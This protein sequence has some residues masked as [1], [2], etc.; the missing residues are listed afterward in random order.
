MQYTLGHGDFYQTCVKNCIGRQMNECDAMQKNTYILTHTKMIAVGWDDFLLIRW[1]ISAAYKQRVW[2]ALTKKKICQV[3]LLS[4][5]AIWDVGRPRWLIKWRPFSFGLEFN[6]LWNRLINVHLWTT[7]TESL[8]I[9]NAIHV[10]QPIREKQT[11]RKCKLN[12]NKIGVWKG[13]VIFRRIL[14]KTV[15]GCWKKANRFSLTFEHEINAKSKCWN[16]VSR[17]D[18]LMPLE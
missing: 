4:W 3:K 18:G 17:E 5:A 13:R 16:F 1:K 2:I 12:S 15:T 10:F 8:K 14:T 11:D 6:V 9:I 7:G